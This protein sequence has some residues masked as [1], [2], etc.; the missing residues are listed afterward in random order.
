MC[1]GKQG[2]KLGFT[3]LKCQDTSQV[4]WFDK[5][6]CNIVN[7]RDILEIGVLR[8]DTIIEIAQ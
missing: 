5:Y 2:R 7:F 3:Q 1:Y 8:T 4:L 6:S